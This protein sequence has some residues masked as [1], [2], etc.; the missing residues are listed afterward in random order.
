[1]L[2]DG[3]SEISKKSALKYLEVVVNDAINV[4]G[5]TLYLDYSFRYGENRKFIV[6]TKKTPF[7]LMAFVA[8]NIMSYFQV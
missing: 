6:E 8:I 7:S 3:I 2:S 1:M 5:K 4:H